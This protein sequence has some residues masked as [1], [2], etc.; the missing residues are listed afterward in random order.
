MNG[1]LWTNEYLSI[2]KYREYRHW[3]FNRW[4]TIRYAIHNTHCDRKW[5][6][7]RPHIR[8]VWSSVQVIVNRW[9]REN[10]DRELFNRMT[11]S[12]SDAHKRACPWFCSFALANLQVERGTCLG[13]GKMPYV[14][15]WAVWRLGICSWAISKRRFL[16]RHSYS[17]RS[18]TD[19]RFPLVYWKSYSIRLDT[20]SSHECLINQAAWKLSHIGSWFRFWKANRMHCL[21]C[22]EGLPGETIFPFVVP[23]F[24]WKRCRV[25]S[26]F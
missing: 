15:A 21:C 8:C 22:S 6:I 16:E 24:L 19:I 18:K 17:P 20:T 9:G 2:I 14:I 4:I 23:L 13:H 26:W 11:R 12:V 25:V 3:L 1:E 7:N 5:S 10:Q